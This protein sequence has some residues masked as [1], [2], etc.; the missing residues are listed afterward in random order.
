MYNENASHLVCLVGHVLALH[1]G[2]HLKPQTGDENAAAAAAIQKGMSLIAPAWL[3]MES[4]L[5]IMF[6]P[7]DSNATRD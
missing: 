3:Q 7:I 1:N 2:K 5:L 6:T 4:G